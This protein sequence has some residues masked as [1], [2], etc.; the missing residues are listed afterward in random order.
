MTVY[1][2]RQLR[3]NVTSKL[4]AVPGLNRLDDATGQVPMDPD[5]RAHPYC[6]L[7]TGSG[8]SPETAESLCGGAGEFDW[9]FQITCAGG[10]IDRAEWA[11]TR[12]RGALLRTRLTPDSGIVR[13]DYAPDFAIQDTDVAPARWYFPV[14][15]TVTLP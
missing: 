12:A 10:D 4:D 5:G 8:H 7:Y 9:R 14:I 13:E 15:Y 6:V 11:L 3:L 1:T 2:L